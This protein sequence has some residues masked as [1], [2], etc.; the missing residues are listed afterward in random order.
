MDVAIFQSIQQT[1]ISKME[2]SRMIVFDLMKED[3][4]YVLDPY[5]LILFITKRLPAIPGVAVFLGPKQHKISPEILVTSFR[6]SCLE[7]DD[8]IVLIKSYV[9]KQHQDL[10]EIVIIELIRLSFALIF[11]G[12]IVDDVDNKTDQSFYEL[13]LI[14]AF[15]NDGQGFIT[16]IAFCVSQPF[17]TCIRN[18]FHM[19]TCGSFRKSNPLAEVVGPSKYVIQ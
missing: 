15:I 16:F 4:L 5:S 7:R 1:Q 6:P 9:D 2:A 14:N 12:Y 10:L 11:I 3:N 8:A 13:Q 17:Q 19:I 18:V